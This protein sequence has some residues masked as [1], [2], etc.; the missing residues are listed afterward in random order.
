MALGS[1]IALCV[2]C[3]LA[4]PADKRT[5]ITVATSHLHTAF[6]KKQYNAVLT[7][8]PGTGLYQWSVSAGQLPQGLTLSGTSGQISGRPTQGGTFPLTIAVTDST[9]ATGSKSLSL[10][11][12]EQ[13]TDIYG[14][15]TNLACPNGVQAHFY[16]QKIGSRWHLCTPAGNAFWMNGVYHVD[17]TDAGA[18]YQGVV[19][20]NV[21]NAKYAAGFTTNPTL[22]WA[23]QSV[24]RMQS[25]GFNTI[26]EDAV[27]WTLPVAVH[28]DWPTVDNTI[29]VKMPFVAIA[30]PSWYSYT[31]A[32][33]WASGPVKDLI[34]GVKST[35]YTGYR[36]HSADFWDPNFAQWFQN[37]LINDYWVHQ[38][39][40]GP[41]KDYLISITV[42]DTDFLQGF[43]AGHDFPTTNNGAIS[44]GYDQPHLGW[45]I[46]VTAPTQSSS[47]YF[48]LTYTNQTVYAKQELSNWLSA[49][50]SGSIAS[51]N[52]AW[53]SQYSSFGSSGGWG[54]GTGLLDE[55]GTCPA[56]I[57]ICWV[58]A[59]ALGLSGATAPMQ[60]D[61]DDFLLHHAQKYFSTI[62]S[63]LQ[64]Q[65]PGVL[66]NG[67]TVLGTYGTP[68]RRQI[69]QAAGA[70][71]DLL[72]L[73]SVPP[74]CSNCTDVQQRV[75]FVAQYGGDKPWLNWEG[76][77]A[78][79]D[80]YMSPYASVSDQLQTQQ[81]RGQL[82]Q[83]RMQQFLNT[84]DTTT[85]TYHLVGL[86]WWELYDNR[87]ENANWGLLTRRD[88][89]YDGAA[90]TTAAGADSWGYATG[91]LPTSG[92]EKS[93]YGDFLDL[94]LNANL[95]TLRGIVSLPA[96]PKVPVQDLRLL[97]NPKSPRLPKG[98]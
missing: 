57:S 73:A 97:L 84:Q 72:P 93:S 82:Y 2:A 67:P 27:A 83:Q 40:S 7:H 39:Y 19:L 11:V 42:D 60:K 95:S 75:D 21:V 54:V 15:L 31:N 59:D 9:G 14:G 63:S 38:A 98:Q 52:T 33:N 56:K 22:N 85:G 79:A 92:C 26:A 46:L 65:A 74:I 55:D 13:P 77:Q 17:A 1:L 12:F 86:K 76:Y 29:P 62:K 5:G 10:Q 45:I 81:A 37:S 50:Y 25:W 69:L 47:A 8:G 89:A 90:A 20:N 91:C 96:A 48:G 78:K 44:L 3:E 71:V 80:S 68:P 30:S 51:L 53:G 23:L 94:L 4:R 18:D 41:N 16:T 66:Y 35:V 87:G 70:Y 36:S 32:N 24:R 34:A 88:N 28:S 61:L 58:P 49:R 64:A 6:L 43:G